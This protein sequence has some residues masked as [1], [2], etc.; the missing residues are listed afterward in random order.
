MKSVSINN[1]RIL[2][3]SDGSCGIRSKVE[4][5]LQIKPGVYNDTILDGLDYLLLEM[6][7][8]DMVAILYLNNSWEWSG[9]YSQYL[10]WS[11]FGEAPVP[12]EK[13]WDQF[14]N[15]V[16]KFQ[17]SDKA[18]ELFSNYVTDIITRENRY[19]NKKYTDDPTIMSWQIAN[20][21]RPFADENKESFEKWIADVAKQIK[22]LDKNHLV[23]TGSEGKHGCEGDIEL[24]DRVHSDKNIDYLNIHIW[25]Y[26][27]G[28]ANKESLYE[29]VE[30]AKNNALNY[31]EEHHNI[32]KRLQKPV[33]LEEFGYPR[34]EFKF[35]KTTSTT[36]RDIFY[37]YIFDLITDET[38]FELFAGCNFWA[39]GGFAD[40]RN[41]FWQKGDDY[42]GDPAQE[43]QGLNSVFSSDKTIDLIKNANSILCK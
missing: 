26:N 10:E 23:S 6:G 16:N 9:G 17:K 31:I 1:L 32:A 28:W 15:Y 14:M 5:T 38:K 43:E 21:P 39:W 29:D 41:E 30:M 2:V 8:R 12:A 24:Y 36:A 18:K 25:P 22:D 7:K 42:T 35:C 11:G 33:V 40:P 4:P 13:G 37:G 27:W 3:G 34:D 20:E 19:T